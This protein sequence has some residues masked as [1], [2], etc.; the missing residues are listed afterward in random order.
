MVSLSLWN[1][2]RLRFVCGLPSCGGSEGSP[3]DGG[4]HSGPWALERSRL[5]RF[6]LEAMEQRHQQEVAA[7]CPPRTGRTRKN[8]EQ[9]LKLDPE[10]VERILDFVRSRSVPLPGTGEGWAAVAFHPNFALIRH[11]CG[12]NSK[13]SVFLKDKGVAV[14]AK[15][16]IAAGQEITVSLA[17]DLEPTWKRRAR[18]YRDH[19]LLCRCSRCSDPTELGSNLSALGCPKC[20][21][22]GGGAGGGAILPQNP[23]DFNSVWSCRVHRGIRMSAR[24][25]QRLQLDLQADL[26]K[27][28][29]TTT[30]PRL[31]RQISGYSDLLHPN[32]G[33]V[34]AA[35]RSL[36]H[37]FGQVPAHSVTRQM[38]ATIRGLCQE[39]LQVLAEVDPG[40]PDWKG[41]VLKHLSTANLN[42]ARLDLEEARIQR[43]EFL[44]RVKEAMLMVKEAVRCQSSS[45]MRVQDGRSRMMSGPGAEDDEGEGQSSSSSSAW[46]DD[47]LS[48]SANC[49]S[50]TCSTD[51]SFF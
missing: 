30:I 34:M 6:I 28:G 12:A 24:S 50:D 2:R 19:L 18:L 48:D 20:G 42:L 7:A 22:G 45:G 14:Q 43:P 31:Q 49:M 9:T 40:Y 51:G 38:L 21:G 13:F 3:D 26:Y 17:H 27:A 25:A 16:F 10:E 1:L 41:D 37:C 33:L 15:A 5:A 47:F 46:L 4:P 36:I 29:T 32:H 35:K 39:Q 23:L 8:R 11:R 44:A